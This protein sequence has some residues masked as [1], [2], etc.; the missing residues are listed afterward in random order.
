MTTDA[1]IGKGLWWDESW[2]PTVGCTP[3]QVGCQHCYARAVHNK[4]HKAYLAGKK[5]PAQYAKPFSEVQLIEKRLT[6]PLHWR[7]PRTVFVDS[8]SDLFHADVPFDFIDKVF[9]TMALCLHHT[10][11]VLTK[12]PERMEAYLID[13]AGNRDEICLPN[14]WLGTSISN[15]DDADRNI[16]HLLRCPAARRIVSYEPM[17][18]RVDFGPFA[19]CYA[20]YELDWAILGCESGVNRRSCALDWVRSAIRDCRERRLPIFVKQLDIGGRVSKNPVEWPGWAR[21]R[22]LP[23]TNGG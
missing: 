3:N 15:Q 1:R 11:I 20:T 12:R 10:F 21:R 13:T 16:P 2:N 5:M 14:V 19:G 17:L 18:G 8:V 6:V 7:K 9:A 4:R 23:V 22:E